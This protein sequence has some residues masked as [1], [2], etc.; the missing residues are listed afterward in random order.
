MTTKAI[1]FFVDESAG[2][3]LV[4]W[5]ES[6]G[7]AVM[8]VIRTE[9]GLPDQDVLSRC[10]AGGYVL[11]TADKDFGDLVF[12]Q[13]KPHHGVV[14]L[15]LADARVPQKI[16][17][18]RKLLAHHSDKLQDNFCIVTDKAVRIIELTVN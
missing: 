5:L 9:Q 17:A 1:K 15:R 2:Y 18:M 3:G 16:E 12:R 4:E 6:Q 10:F 14:L 11:I 8:C 13:Y 7:F